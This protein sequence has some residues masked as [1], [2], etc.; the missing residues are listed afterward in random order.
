ME[1]H[2]VEGLTNEALEQIRK[3][4]DVNTVV[5]TPI[6]VPDGTT[7]IPISKVALGFG[8]GGSEFSSA[9]KNTS[10]PDGQA[11]FGGASGGG[12]TITPVAFLVAN[13]DQIKL[14]PITK[15][16]TTADKI[17]DLV[18]DLIT[19]FNKIANEYMEKRTAKKENK[20]S[21]DIE[22]PQS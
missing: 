13:K 20:K 12:V 18:P 10:K 5:G 14:L 8:S 3:M 2:P 16:N 4:M 17:I 7:I 9:S 21:N 6:T 22:L 1:R 11:L 19:K 15:S